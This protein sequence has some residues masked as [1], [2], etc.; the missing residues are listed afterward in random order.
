MAY[1]LTWCWERGITLANCNDEREQQYPTL[2]GISCR[3]ASWMARVAVDGVKLTDGQAQF[4]ERQVSGGERL[5]IES[6]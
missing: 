1:G 5:S 6:G 4:E 2:A 3:H